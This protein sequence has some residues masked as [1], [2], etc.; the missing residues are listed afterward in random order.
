MFE[1]ATIIPKNY[2][3][4]TVNIYSAVHFLARQVPDICPIP[5][6]RLFS[7]LSILLQI[8]VTRR[9]SIVYHRA[10]VTYMLE[11]L[12]PAAQERSAMSGSQG[13]LSRFLMVNLGI[14]GAFLL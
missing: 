13:L 11:E 7:G 1:K 2:L 5:P 6:F 8:L 4:I 10:L 3:H 12:H 9:E 14:S